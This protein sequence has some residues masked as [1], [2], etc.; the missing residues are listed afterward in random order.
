MVKNKL[1]KKYET[2]FNV[3]THKRLERGMKKYG[4]N[5]W[6]YIDALDE[7]EQEILDIRNYALFLWI[8]IRELSKDVNIRRRRTGMSENS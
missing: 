2:K 4:E 6:Q 3:E 8:K 7:L 5:K 1:I